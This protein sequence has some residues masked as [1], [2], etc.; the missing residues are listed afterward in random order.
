M[1]RPRTPGPQ[2][3]QPLSHRQILLVAALLGY[4]G[5]FASVAAAEAAGRPSPPADPVPAYFAG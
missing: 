4:I 3:P 1:T 5:G 2:L